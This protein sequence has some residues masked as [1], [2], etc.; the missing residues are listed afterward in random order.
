MGENCAIELGRNALPVLSVG[1]FD[2]TSRNFTSFTRKTPLVLVGISSHSCDRCVVVETEYHAVLPQLL[3]QGIPFARVD[4][5]SQRHVVE[6]FPEMT[7]PALYLCGTKLPR[8]GKCIAY[9]GYHQADDILRFVQRLQSP[10]ATNLDTMEDVMQWIGSC[11]DRGDDR[12]DFDSMILGFFNSDEHEEEMEEYWEAAVDSLHIGRLRFGRILVPKVTTYF[13]KVKNWFARSPAVVVQRCRPRQDDDKDNRDDRNDRDDKDDKDEP[14]LRT[15]MLLDEF[16]G[17]D[18]LSLSTWIQQSSL[19]NVGE[20]TP[21]NFA[22]YETLKL[23]MLIGFMNLV[24][25]KSKWTTS[26]MKRILARAARQYKGRMVVV[27]TNGA[28]YK[29]RMRSLGILNGVQS[30]PALSINTMGDA[31]PVI[32]F[33]LEQLEKQVKEVRKGRRS[34]GLPS[35]MMTDIDYASRVV[36]Y[37]EQF[38]TGRL[39][40]WK[41]ELVVT[42]TSDSSKSSSKSRSRDSQLQRGVREHFNSMEDFVVPVTTMDKTFNTI[43]MD[44]TR[45]VVVLLHAEDGSCAACEHLAPYY[46]KFAKRMKELHVDTV[47]VARMDISKT[48][49]PS[50]IEISRLPVIVLYRAYA[51]AP[52]HIYYSGVAKVRP[53]MDWI[54]H[55]AGKAFTYDVMLPQFDRKDAE[56]FKRQIEKRERRKLKEKNDL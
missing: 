53:M 43:V 30:L 31:N 47:V 18:M 39:A 35:T 17:Q 55:H 25:I 51:K 11:V 42:T 46:K 24:S 50:D 54:Q 10:M 45:D 27:Y 23:P 32:P 15:S 6:D 49:P 5:D 13:Q 20:L 36:Q 44:E 41:E 28:L 33:F 8:G 37:C 4:A 29:D 21:H 12:V 34:K 38:L 16:Y 19:P 52:P 14:S 56:L 22:L 26:R 9:D 48:P 2:L 7:L 3:Q 1:S 40:L